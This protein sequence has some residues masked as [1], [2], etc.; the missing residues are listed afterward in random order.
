MSCRAGSSVFAFPASSR[1]AAGNKFCPSASS[2]WRAVRS[3][4]RRRL[5]GARQSW[6]QLGFAL[7]AAAPWCSSRNSLLNR[8]AA[9]LLDGEL[10]LTV[11]NRHPVSKPRRT[12]ARLLPV[13]PYRYEGA[14]FAAKHSPSNPPRPLKPP[15]WHQDT[16]LSTHAVSNPPVPEPSN[17]I[18]HP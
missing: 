8:S 9:D 18:Q 16:D 4:P 7:T 15:S 3:H 2:C 17:P 11:R 1:I 13:C 14:P 6:P 10:S 5:Q 12:S